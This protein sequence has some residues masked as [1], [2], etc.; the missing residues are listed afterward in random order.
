VLERGQALQSF[1]APGEVIGSDEGGEVGAELVVA[2]I[3]VAP[4][5]RLLEGAVHPLDLTIRPGMVWPGQAMIDAVLSADEL[6][7]MRP[8]ELT[9]IE[10][11]A[12]ELGCRGHI[13]GRGELHAIAGEHGAHLV[14]HR[15]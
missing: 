5:R 11:L 2:F 9:A 15:L 6:E 8:D 10:S 7:A 4:D 14:G 12:D 3:V 13:T 1:E